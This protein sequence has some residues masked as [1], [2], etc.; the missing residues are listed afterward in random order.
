M[1]MIR[2]KMKAELGFTVRRQSDYT[3]GYRRETVYLD[4]YNE[5]KE[6]MFRLKYL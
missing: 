5:A 3:N 1:V 4:F 2:E 6:T